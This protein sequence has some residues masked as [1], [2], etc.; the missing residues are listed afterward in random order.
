MHD[1]MHLNA[2]QVKSCMR[3]IGSGIVLAASIGA[4]LLSAIHLKSE[5]TPP[6]KIYGQH[7][8]GDSQAKVSEKYIECRIVNPFPS[9]T[10]V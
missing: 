8:S 6:L 9:A 7:Y 2:S 1:M 4:L 3:S 5:K 10:L